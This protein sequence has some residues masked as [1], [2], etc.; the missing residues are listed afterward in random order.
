MNKLIRLMWSDDKGQDLAEYG[1]LLILVAV[2]VVGGITLFQAQIVNIFS[3]VTS[4]L[5]GA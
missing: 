4:V 3:Q 1:L 5:S 2:A